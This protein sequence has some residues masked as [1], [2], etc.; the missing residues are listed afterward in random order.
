MSGPST[1]P[2][3]YA[4]GLAASVETVMAIGT[5]MAMEKYHE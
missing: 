1:A 3:E 5:V 4:S 2:D